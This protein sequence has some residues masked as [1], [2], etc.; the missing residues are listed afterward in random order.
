[1]D[2][3]VGGARDVRGTLD[4]PGTDPGTGTD[5]AVVAC[6]PHPQHGGNRSDRRLAAVSDALLDRDVACLRFDYGE[7]D[8]GYGERSDAL[9]ALGWLR[10]RY[11]RVGA[12]G[13]SFGGG[14][15]LL[16]SEAAGPEPDAVSALAPASR[17]AE[18]L[19]ATAALESLDCPVQIVYGERD[20]TAEWEPVVERA[21]SLGHP[22]VELSADHFF[23]GQHRKVADHVADFLDRSL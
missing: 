23:V 20:T 16:A 18:D 22:V 2:V 5:R 3:L 14:I 13:F 7:W 6:P 12:F 17:L 11:D 1:M 8:R 19:D 21:R 9:A 15:A 10:E 4:A